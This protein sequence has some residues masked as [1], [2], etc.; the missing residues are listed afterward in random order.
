[1]TSPVPLA[2]RIVRRHAAVVF[3]DVPY[4]RVEYSNGGRISAVE[5]A[6]MLEPQLGFVTNVR[7]RASLSGTP[8]TIAW[9]G[10]GPNGEV[11]SGMLVIHAAVSESEV[12][13]WAE[14]DVEG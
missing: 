13:T 3:R 4:T 9:E 7:F 1:M 5:L 14:V 10:L 12:V 8:N 2:L 6:R 11:V